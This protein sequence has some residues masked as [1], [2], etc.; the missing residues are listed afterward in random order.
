MTVI[1][2]WIELW[3]RDCESDIPSIMLPHYN[4]FTLTAE[5]LYVACFDCLVT[6]ISSV[7]L[8]KALTLQQQAKPSKF[9]RSSSPVYG[10]PSKGMFSS[11]LFY[12]QDCFGGLWADKPSRH[13]TSHTG[14]LSLASPPWV[15]TVSSLQTMG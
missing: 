2:L 3:P 5:V 7:E 13:V 1:R 14:Q 15:G 10:S 12:F 4:K 8:H 6:R 11:F 9:E